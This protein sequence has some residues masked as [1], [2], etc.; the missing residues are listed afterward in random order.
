VRVLPQMTDLELA[1]KLTGYKQVLC[2]VKTRRHARNLYSCEG[3]RKSAAGGGPKPRHPG[4][5]YPIQ[6]GASIVSYSLL[7]CI[8]RPRLLRI[9]RT[10]VLWI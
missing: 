8:F 10:C 1:E 6:Y 4:P 5:M 2:I 3:R 7:R 9:H